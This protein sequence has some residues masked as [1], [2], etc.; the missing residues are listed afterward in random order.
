MPVLESSYYQIE[1]IDDH[2]MEPPPIEREREGGPAGGGRRKTFKVGDQIK[3]GPSELA[4]PHSV[5]PPFGLGPLFEREKEWTRRARD[6]SIADGAWRVFRKRDCNNNACCLAR[7]IARSL[8]GRVA[9]ETR[10]GCG[11]RRGILARD[12]D[13]L[14]GALWQNFESMVA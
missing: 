6:R 1:E 14:E 3:D 11:T 13:L 8:D 4:L 2:A 10:G 5:R 9:N 12:A 7:S